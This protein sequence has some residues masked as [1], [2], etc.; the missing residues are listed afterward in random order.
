MTSPLLAT[1]LYLP[2]MRPNRVSRPHLME[3]LRQGLLP[4]CQLVLVSAP[5]GFGKTTLA[6]EWA[7]TAGLPAAWLSLDEKDNDPLRFWHY[8]IAALQTVDPALGQDMDVALDAP[9]PP[10]V[11]SLLIFL[12]NDL[13]Q[14]RKPLLLLLDD[15]H[16]IENRAIHEGLNFLLDHNPPDIHI[17]LLTRAD[18]PLQLAR[19]RARAEL[20]EL[21]AGDL[22]F[23]PE[24]TGEFFQ[25]AM[26]LPL[27]A[28]DII[29][30]EQRTEGWVA[31]LQMAAVA[32]QGQPADR[33]TFIAAFTGDDRYIADYL[34]EEVLQHQTAAVQRFLFKTSILERFCASLCD[35]LEELVHRP[36][37]NLIRHPGLSR[38][39][40]FIPGAPRQP[41]RMVPLP[42]FVCPTAPPASRTGVW[43][44]CDARVLH[45]RRPLAPEAR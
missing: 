44:G 25:H 36:G 31:G 43:G 18:P 20:V 2:R 13:I 4:G 45:A 17:A 9:A 11:E 16:L 3:R 34:V 38:P 15:Y 30:L 21:R 12:V 28:Q 10:P 40:Q 39:R 29:A 5:A 23:T 8:L 14:F 22:R 42:P 24:E 32:M 7:H 37:G 26:R 19:R 33:Q 6:A 35:A 27:A 41:A 1:K